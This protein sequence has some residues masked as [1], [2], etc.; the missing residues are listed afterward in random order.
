MAE[1]NHVGT[2]GAIVLFAER[3]AVLRPDTEHL[4]EL[5]RDRHGLHV[6][7]GITRRKVESRGSSPRREPIEQFQVVAEIEILRASQGN[8]IFVSGAP[9]ELRDAV[10]FGIRQGPQQD[11]IHHAE[12]CG[13]RAGAER[14]REHGRE[15]E[16]GRA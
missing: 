5:L 13:I 2:A 16:S 7:G 4:E 10:G 8:P 3:V 1:H 12:D 15:G 11:C 14:K 9:Y 6:F